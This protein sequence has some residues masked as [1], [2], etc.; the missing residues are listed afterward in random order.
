MAD[1]KPTPDIMGG[2]L[3]GRLE[4]PEDT[5]T[6]A[7]QRTSKPAK[8][9]AGKPVQKPQKGSSPPHPGSAPSAK[10]K[11]TFYLSPETVEA[12]DDGVYRLK[13]LV[14]PEHKAKASKS[15]IVEAALRLVLA[16]LEETG[17]DCQLASMLAGQ[18][19][20]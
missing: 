8:K 10:E 16:E 20:G 9:Q 19:A 2:L 17:P 11:A 12:L 4:A 18:P 7:G 6:P 1:R 14:K 5:S 15:F 13:K 3:S